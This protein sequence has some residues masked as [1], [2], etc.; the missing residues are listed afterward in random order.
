VCRTFEMT[1]VYI[2]TSGIVFLNV[3]QN[4]KNW[5]KVEFVGEFTKLLLF[6]YD[7]DVN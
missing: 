2:C 4:E 7:V 6:N 5:E 1:H 3:K